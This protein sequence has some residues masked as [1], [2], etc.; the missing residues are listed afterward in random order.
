MSRAPKS[1]SVMIEFVRLQEAGNLSF[2]FV[3]VFRLSE[4]IIAS[5]GF[6]SADFGFLKCESSV[7]SRL[8]PADI[9]FT[10]SQGIS[11]SWD[12]RAGCS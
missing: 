12:P 4:R 1:I 8:I 3:G 9:R 5:K 11:L 2:S 6:Y 7:K 10:I